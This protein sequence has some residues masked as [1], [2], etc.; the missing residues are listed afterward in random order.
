MFPPWPIL[1]GKGFVSRGFISK[2]V[3]TA[4]VLPGLNIKELFEPRV[5]FYKEESL[6]W[7][8]VLNGKMHSRG[9]GLH[10]IF[11]SVWHGREVRLYV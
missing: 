6:L 1:K 9:V 3:A 2:S 10:G 4:L 8:L 7:K 11:H 5:K